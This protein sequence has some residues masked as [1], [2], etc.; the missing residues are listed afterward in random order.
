MTESL[1]PS[2]VLGTVVE[3]QSSIVGLMVR[4]QRLDRPAGVETDWL[5]IAAPMA[6]EAAGVSF[7]PEAGDVAVAA[8]HGTRP[9]VLGFVYGGGT[10]AP[11]TDPLE[12]IVQSRDGNAL[13]LVDGE[14]SGI[15]LRD[16]HGNEIRMDSGGIS[17]TTG[18][19][20]TISATGTTTITGATVELNP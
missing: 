13:I 16:K 10:T 14:K 17:I 15:T 9:I 7:M 18:K 12:R 2:L 3:T 20:L 1:A 4:L 6:G 19:D 8:F 11:S 5:Q